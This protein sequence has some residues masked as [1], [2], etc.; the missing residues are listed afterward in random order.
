[1]LT[2][3]LAGKI[4]PAKPKNVIL[5]IGDGMG[6]AE[7]TL[8]RYYG[9]GAAGRLNMDS[10]P[11]RGS[12]IHYVLK[13][14]PGPSYVPNHAGDSAPT[15]TAWSRDRGAN[16]VPSSSSCLLSPTGIQK[17]GGLS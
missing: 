7:V 13:A 6:D 4:E 1:M 5:M 14:G 9:K 11:F 2:A 12:S 16:P 3:G 15:A 17:A 8:G 10:L